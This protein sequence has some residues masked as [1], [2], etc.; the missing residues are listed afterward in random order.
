[1]ARVLLFLLLQDEGVEVIPSQVF[2]IHKA[3]DQLLHL[4]ADIGLELAIVVLSVKLLH[5]VQLVIHL[6][7]T[8][9]LVVQV[10]KVMNLAHPQPLLVE[11][12]QSKPIDA[13]SVQ[14]VAVGEHRVNHIAVIMFFLLLSLL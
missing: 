11:I 13:E 3:C 7:G 5:H 2:L 14:D 12:L 8:N 9:H 1:M 4:F 10:E 6:N